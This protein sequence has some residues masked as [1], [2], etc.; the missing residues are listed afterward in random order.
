[1]RSKVPNICHTST[2][3]SQILLCFSLGP[4]VIELQV[5]FRQSAPNDRMTLNFKRPMI[6]HTC[7]TSTLESQISTCFALRAT[8]FEL[9]A[10]LI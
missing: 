9:R 2:P 6:P 4:A 3:E 1:M 7:F 10:I 5:I 8:V